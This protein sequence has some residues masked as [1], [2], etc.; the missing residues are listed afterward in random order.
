MGQ[1]ENSPIDQAI[2]IISKKWTLNIIRDMFCGSNHFNEFLKNNSRLSSKVLSDKLRQL[3]QDGLI[4]KRS[5]ENKQ[6][7]IEYHLTSKGRALNKVLYEISGFAYSECVDGSA[8]ECTAKSYELTKKILN[9]PDE[10]NIS[11]GSD[12]SHLF[13]NPEQ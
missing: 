12:T 10:S 4:E 3:E 9:I 6:M 7:G 2:K 13:N 5:I 1:L 8:S 11:N